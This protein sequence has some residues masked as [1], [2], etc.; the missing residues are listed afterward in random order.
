MSASRYPTTQLFSHQYVE[1]AGAVIFSLSKQQI[2]IIR[3]TTTNELYLPKGRRNCNEH[4]SE[5]ALREIKEETGLTCTFLPVS[6]KTRTPPSEEQEY[7]DEVRELEEVSG[8]P[9][10]L[11]IRE[12]GEHDVK[13]IWWYIVQ[14]DDVVEDD[15]QK[16]II[17]GDEKFETVFFGFDEVLK[18][19][20]FPSDRELVAKAL[21]IV[22]E[23]L[24]KESSK[25]QS[26]YTVLLHST[27]RARK[28]AV[29]E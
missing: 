11:T 17:P 20:T 1:S 18:V 12:L 27:K 22:N 5:T 21:E 23:T 7:P 9:F 10:C 26:V 3:N 13:L 15:A 8:E 2:C 28:G 14:M 24:Q 19:L 29:K 16:K 25:F 6:M 4:R